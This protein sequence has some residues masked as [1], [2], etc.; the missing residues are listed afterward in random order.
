MQMRNF[1]IP[2]STCM[3]DS[4]SI[5]LIFMP[6]RAISIIAFYGVEFIYIILVLLNQS[7]IILV[8]FQLNT[9]I[10]KPFLVRHCDFQFIKHYKYIAEHCKNI[11]GQY[12][13]KIVLITCPL[14]HTRKSGYCHLY[15]LNPSN[16]LI[17]TKLKIS[18]QWPFLVS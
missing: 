17:I 2:R 11:F 12:Q 7:F 15:W 8:L 1:S 14:Q 13:Q 9:T 18:Q 4:K 6:S 10:T 3:N 16:P 5:W